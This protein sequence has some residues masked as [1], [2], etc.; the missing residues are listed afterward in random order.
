[1]LNIDDKLAELPTKSFFVSLFAKSYIL[2][3]PKK[4]AVSAKLILS[5]VPV[6]HRL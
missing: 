2:G 4:I 3:Q 6:V 1:M 5:L